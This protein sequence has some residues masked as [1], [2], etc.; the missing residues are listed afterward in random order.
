MSA[1]AQVCDN[2]LT[3]V[4]EQDQDAPV[5]NEVMSGSSQDE[6]VV[7]IRV[8]EGRRK[9]VVDLT[10]SSEDE[11]EEVKNEADG[12]KI[13]DLTGLPSDDDSDSEKTGGLVK[14]NHVI[15]DLCGDNS[16]E[17]DFSC[18][19]KRPKLLEQKNAVQS[20]LHFLSDSCTSNSLPLEKGSI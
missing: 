10:G 11:G 8:V 4:S 15:I 7:I 1:L 6:E 12:F 17:E 2:S 3:P 14:Q 18:P 5:K 16:D 20:M 19:R 13:I 9:R